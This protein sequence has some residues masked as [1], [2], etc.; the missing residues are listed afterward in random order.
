M[1]DINIGHVQKLNGFGKPENMKLYN[2][3]KNE[4][5]KSQ[6]KHSLFRS[7]RIQKEYKSKN[8]TYTND[9]PENTGIKGWM[10]S[11]WI[12]L[13]DFFHD[14]NIVPCGSSNTEQ[15]YGEYPL[16]R[17][18]E[19]A[20]KLGRK[21]ILTM[22]EAKDILK[23]K[24]LKTEK[25][26]HTKKYNITAKQSGGVKPNLTIKNDIDAVKEEPMSDIIISKYLKNPK[27]I[28]YREF[29][30]YNNIDQLLPNNNDYCIILFR[31]SDSAHWIAILKQNDIIEHFC[32]YGSKPDQYYFDWNTQNENNSLEQ[33]EPYLSNL[34]KNCKYEVI[35]NPIK[36]QKISN[37]IASCGRHCVIRI[38]AML[39]HDYN[40][41]NYYDYMKRKKN[42]LQ[43]SYDEIVSILVN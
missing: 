14:G 6:P 2:Q 30:N 23:E 5:I 42:E 36:Y 31:S 32:S 41:N 38:V 27:I 4:I 3:V 40:L 34:L 16:C 33:Y 24:P 28:E 39:N 12:S 11:E 17:P 22:I 8:G 37:D 15:K 25:V 19:I 35:Y 10:K 7:A 21:Q 20:K 9:K 26:L 1:N 13:N 18:L 43:L 29:K